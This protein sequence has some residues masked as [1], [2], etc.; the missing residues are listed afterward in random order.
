MTHACPSPKTPEPICGNQVIGRINRLAD[1][2]EAVLNASKELADDFAPLGER[3]RKYLKNNDGNSLDFIL[4]ECRVLREERDYLPGWL[5]AMPDIDE[6]LWNQ[7]PSMR[8]YA[9]TLH[10][11][12]I[13]LRI[14]RLNELTGKPLVQATPYSWLDPSSLLPR[15]W[16]YGYCLIRAFVSLVVA[17]GA[18]G[19]SAM[20]IAEALALVTGRDL[21]GVP[22]RGGPYRVWLW[23]LEDPLDELL[24]RI[25][26]TCIHFGITAADI[27]DRFFVDS[28]RDQ[29]L[30]IAKQD[31]NG[32]E[33]LEP[34]VS[35]LVAELKMRGIDVLIVDPFV[36]SHAVTENDNNA[37]DAVMKTW[38][39][40]A[41]QANCAIVLIHHLRKLGSEQASAESA[42]G[43]SSLVAAARSVRV[44]Q[45]MTKKEA[46]GAGLD[47]PSG[48]FQVFD[49]KNNLAPPAENAAWFHMPSVHLPNGD[50]VGVVESW[51]YPKP[52]A[53]VTTDDLLSVQRAIAGKGLKKSPQAI[54]WA[55]YT[56]GKVLGFDMTAPANRK[57]VRIMMNTWLSNG[58]LIV[59]ELPDKNRK[60]RPCVDVGEWVE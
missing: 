5:E 35:E 11:K 32:F 28:G 54:D 37:V 26:A 39:R 1:E 34:V 40:V 6:T 13:T 44:L 58:A 18:A 55:G 7:I 10:S 31:R 27:D 30:C 19:K 51:E 42:R 21:L 25:A 60:P 24:R 50:N 48:Y 45:R 49:D 41:D 46:D 12:V 14:Q 53:G 22:V 52:F 43:A 9:A 38:G 56:V 17:P 23:N 29:G 2:A 4:R 47:N 16:L 20:M 33:I 3:M 36:S 57:R 15:M 59:I 8:E